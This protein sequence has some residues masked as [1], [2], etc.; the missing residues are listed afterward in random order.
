MLYIHQLNHLT[1][2]MADLESVYLVRELKQKTAYPLQENQLKELFLPFFISGEELVMI[3]ES[4]N[5]IE[6]TIEQVKSLLQKQSSLYETINLQRAVQ[7]LKSLPLHLQ[8]NLTFLQEF[9]VWQNT[10]PND[11][12][13]LFNRVP[14]LRSMEEKMKANEEIKKVFGFLLRNPEFFFQ[15]QDVVNEG[16]VSTINGLSEGLEKGFF[17]H[18]TLEEETKKLEYGIIKR[19][20]PT[21]ELSLVGEIEKNIRC[22]KEAIDTAYKANMGIINLAVVLYASVKWLSGK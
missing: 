11:V 10:A 21:E 14:Q 20:I 6:P 1:P 15:Y 19:R 13:L 3:E 8:N 9:Q 2:K 4:L 16:Q 12:A 5:L 7:M 18:V 17:F 22:I